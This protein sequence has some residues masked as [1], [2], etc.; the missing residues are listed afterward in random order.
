MSN[1]ILKSKNQIPDGIG[2]Y[3]NKNYSLWRQIKSKTKPG[4]FQLYNEFLEYMPSLKGGAISLY[5]Y[6]GFYSNNEMGDSWHSIERIAKSLNVTERS[7]NNWNKDLIELGLIYRTNLEMKTTKT[8]LLPLSDYYIK[9]N[10]N[11]KDYLDKYKKEI[12]GDLVSAY[13]LFQWRKGD[14][15]DYDS[16]YN[17]LCFVF[18]KVYTAKNIIDD[19]T[20]KEKQ[21]IKR[22]FVIS[23][24]IAEN[25][26]K[27]D[28]DSNNFTKED[29]I[30]GFDSMI[31]ENVLK[32]IINE[33][34][35]IPLKGIA[36]KTDSDLKKPDHLL[37]VLSELRDK[38]TIIDEFNK[39][40][41]VD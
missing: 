17:I 7:I 23:N 10:T 32:D 20:S 25:S 8:H 2:Q 13:H 31:L 9:I 14:G 26:K 12:D 18:E 30:L 19:I 35:N 6:Y 29:S 16:P 36:I 4:F 22:K 34:C 27:I 3:L 28:R 38:E 24:D 21:Y 40:N 5:L 39:V 11:I 1:F 15:L 37:E 33:E 41:L